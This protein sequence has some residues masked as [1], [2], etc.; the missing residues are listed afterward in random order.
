MG[1]EPA[2]RH[3]RIARPDTF[4]FSAQ[5]FFFASMSLQGFSFHHTFSHCRMPCPLVTWPRSFS[6]SRAP[7]H[8]NQCQDRNKDMKE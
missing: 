1:E 4:F 7:L 2:P 3:S 8:P 6:T 5:P